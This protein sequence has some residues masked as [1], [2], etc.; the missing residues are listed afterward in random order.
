VLAIANAADPP[1]LVL[2]SPGFRVLDGLVYNQLKFRMPLHILHYA[3]TIS[4]KSGKIPN[5]IAQ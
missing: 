3:E 1:A 5:V 4:K 2:K